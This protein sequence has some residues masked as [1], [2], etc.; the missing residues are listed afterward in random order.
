MEKTLRHERVRRRIARFILVAA[1]AAGLLTY[2]RSTPV[3]RACTCE[4]PGSPSEEFLASG[5]VF[6][7]VVIAAAE[8]PPAPGPTPRMPEW[9]KSN[10]DVEL[11]GERLGSMWVQLNR[12]AIN[13]QWYSTDYEL[14]VA[15]S[16]KGIRGSRS[17]GEISVAKR[18]Q[19]LVYET[20]SDALRPVFGPGWPAE[21]L[22][23][24]ER[25][26][27]YAPTGGIGS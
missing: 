17:N 8:I 25:P 23:R 22:A 18:P 3:A 14:A 12:K 26:F 21:G 16:W 20:R 7:G 27:A 10:R 5:A 4:A 15:E 11:F 13:S 1:I 2:S 9:V 24:V 6:R 19:S